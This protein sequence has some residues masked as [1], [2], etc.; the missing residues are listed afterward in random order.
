MA[1]STRA[2]RAAQ[3]VAL[4][5]QAILA[6]QQAAA[7]QGPTGSVRPRNAAAVA[8]R[9]NVPVQR[10]QVAMKLAAHR[11]RQGKSITLA[12]AVATV[13]K[14]Q[15]TAQ[16]QRNQRATAQAFG[17]QQGQSGF[18]QDNMKRALA[19]TGAT[20]SA[21]TAAAYQ[22]S[23]NR[24][25]TDPGAG[26]VL[27]QPSAPPK[28]TAQTQKNISSFRAKSSDVVALSDLRWSEIPDNGAW[29][30][31]FIN[32]LMGQKRIDHSWVL[33]KA[34]QIIEQNAFNAMINELTTQKNLVEASVWADRVQAQGAVTQGLIEI[35]MKEGSEA[36]QGLGN[37]NPTL[38]EEQASLLPVRE[39]QQILGPVSDELGQYMVGKLANLSEDKLNIRKQDLKADKKAEYQGAYYDKYQFNDAEERII[40]EWNDKEK[41]NPHNRVLLESFPGDD[42]PLKLQFLSG[43]EVKVLEK[44][45]AYAATR[46]VN[47]NF[48]DRYMGSRKNHI[49]GAIEHFQSNHREDGMGKV[50]RRL[51]DRNIRLQAAEE[52][53]ARAAEYREGKR[54]PELSPE[55]REAKAVACETHAQLHEKDAL[56]HPTWSRDDFAQEAASAHKRGD[57]EH[58]NELDALARES[59]NM[60]ADSLID[61]IGQVNYQLGRMERRPGA[62]QNQQAIRLKGFVG[63]YH[64]MIE[65]I[66]RKVAAN[67]HMAK[68]NPHAYALQMAMRADLMMR[69]SLLQDALMRPITPRVNQLSG[70]HKEL[71]D[72]NALIHLT[73]QEKDRVPAGSAEAKQLDRRLIALKEQHATVAQQFRPLDVLDGH[74]KRFKTGQTQYLYEEFLM[75]KEAAATHPDAAT[76]KRKMKYIHQEELKMTAMAHEH[77]IQACELY[78]LFADP[79]TRDK[80]KKNVE[81]GKFP[82]L[83]RE[84]MQAH[85]ESMSKRNRPLIAALEGQTDR[86]AADDRRLSLLTQ[87]TQNADAHIG[88]F[89]EAGLFN[90]A[91]EGAGWKWP[92][93]P[94]Q[95][96]PP[97]P[98]RTKAA[99]IA[100]TPDLGTP[101]PL[102]KQTVDV[103]TGK[104]VINAAGDDVAVT[105]PMEVHLP[106]T[107]E[108]LALE[109]DKMMAKGS[110]DP[111][112]LDWRDEEDQREH[113]EAMANGGRF[114]LEG[115]HDGPQEGQLWNLQLW[116]TLVGNIQD[117]LG[118]IKDFT[119]GDSQNASM[120]AA[121][122]SDEVMSLV[123]NAFEQ[124]Y[125]KQVRDLNQQLIQ[126]TYPM[127]NF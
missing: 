28:S 35:P 32:Y 110:D 117:S 127:P 107:A 22:E 86:T 87:L 2:A 43:R 16:T 61:Q 115:Y 81:A 85:M 78:H 104:R 29:N 91:G 71:Q 114:A 123:R 55:A 48:R 106:A 46:G 126:A 5:Q 15:K 52:A 102:V 96:R 67:V 7:Q 72:I 40:K 14:A 38:N 12:Q 45:D 83:T 92:Q 69:V 30:T 51:R 1:D 100:G 13:N 93:A 19:L 3:D 36:N 75:R 8:Q 80:A 94:K 50:G 25:A 17:A 18:V 103:P 74:A 121:G 111:F 27:P 9:F 64:S 98:K 119:Q 62:L 26:P 120:G 49:Q 66:D 10:A 73:T 63:S 105:V 89:K 76:R 97:M 70:A 54:E 34:K 116:N 58:G 6:Q 11:R 57:H 31:Q 53:R 21:G 24:T 113:F 84:I 88:F 108:Q 56:G 23:L 41:D 77:Q 112:K 59:N 65:G 68:D 44:M 118:T 122:L 125:D 95:N 60:L 4:Q 101:L 39:K 33:M 90:S 79:A 42:K 82:Q 109:R 99:T 124:D 37:E 20:A 47:T